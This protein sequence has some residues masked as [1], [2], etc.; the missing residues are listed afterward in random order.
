M[1]DA[2][3]WIHWESELLARDGKYVDA[4]RNEGQVLRI[5][6]QA[7]DEP[8]YIAH[9][10]SLAIES[11]AMQGFRDIMIEAG[12]KP[13]VPEAVFAEVS[14]YRSNRDLAKCLK[15]EMVFG[16]KT[17]HRVSSLHDLN[18]LSP[19]A[20][21]GGQS[22]EPSPHPAS[23]FTK[24]FILAP[25]EA[26]YVHWMTKYVGAAR[27]PLPERTAAM[28]GVQKDFD[29]A[30]TER[31]TYRFAAMF[32]PQYVRAARR[33]VDSAARRLV[34][35]TS[36]AVLVYKSRHGTY[37]A[38]LH[39]AISPAPLDPLGRPLAYECRGGGKGF[40]LVARTNP[41]RFGTTSTQGSW[42]G[43]GMRAGLRFEYPPS[44][45]SA[46]EAPYSGGMYMPGAGA[47]PFAPFRR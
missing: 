39:E 15:G 23:W 32:V 13:G 5:A 22:W 34:V 3:L 18:N 38:T 8:V 16:V 2:A 7:S 31:T 9:R 10:A 12:N 19:A 30:P 26:V 36:A 35:S 1:R 45:P 42:L 6:N 11:V 29:A 41:T 21:D 24:K 46:G 17:L 25:S 44:E 37:P 43:R 28:A 20:W 33:D 27:A 4:V 47:F 14:A 40:I